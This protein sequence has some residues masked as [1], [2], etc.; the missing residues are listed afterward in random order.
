MGL[1]V[2]LHLAMSATTVSSLLSISSLSDDPISENLMSESK[3]FSTSNSRIYRHF[4][5]CNDFFNFYIGG[6]FEN[7]KNKEHNF[8]WWSIFV[9]SFKR[10]RWVN[11]T[12]FAPWLP[13][14]QP[15]FWIFSTPQKLPH[16]TV[17]IPIKFHEVWWKE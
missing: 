12:F 9:S 3:S 11:L 14:Q 13:W 10:I 2:S 4:W 17:D 1:R 7:F 15:P 16:T 8:E 5:I 6:H